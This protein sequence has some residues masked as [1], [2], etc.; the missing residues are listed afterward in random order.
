MFIFEISQ[1]ILV[2]FFIVSIV[3]IGF[4][5][6]FKN[7]DSDRIFYWWGLGL[8]VICLGQMLLGF[9]NIP[10]SQVIVMLLNGLALGFFYFKKGL[11][12]VK[13]LTKDKIWIPI[14][15]ILGLLTFS[16]TIWGSDAYNFWLS[17]ATAFFVDNKITRDNLLVYWPYDHPLLWPLSA[18]WLYHLLGQTNEFWVQIIPFVTLLA[19]YGI[20]YYESQNKSKYFWFG[21][22][23][24]TPFLAGNVYL[25]AYAGNADLLTAFYLLLAI[26]SLL[27]AKYNKAI[28]ICF[29]ATL[30][31]NDALPTFL[32]LIILSP[33]LIKT[34][35]K[36]SL[37]KWKTLIFGIALLTANLIWKQ[38][39]HLDSRYLGQNL[40]E[41][42]QNRPFFAYMK[43]SLMAFRE[44]FRQLY[45]WGIGWWII[46]ATIGIHLDRIFKNKNLLA[47]LL[48]I[49]AQFIGYLWIYYV[50]PEDQASQIATSIF[51]LSLQIY[52]SLLFI[53]F[54]ANV[55]TMKKS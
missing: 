41:I 6:D 29:L 40:A 1:L 28:F 33:F 38:Y 32:A 11:T 35:T 2:L 46:I 37:I 50:T 7:R 36:L 18:T 47:A 53:A 20:V 49:M 44:E 23:L 34:K 26:S 43:Y 30:C 22:L 17:K 52:P 9:L 14:I 12:R 15:L 54:Q 55:K 45:R 8:G 31:K 3:S 42:L 5:F 27:K 13:F 10:L 4:I 39:Y 19:I 24:A 16:H 48:L 25:K 21:I 51:R